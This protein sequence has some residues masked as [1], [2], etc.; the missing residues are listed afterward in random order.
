M[1]YAD[2]SV[3]VSYYC[4]EPLT[5]AVQ[6]AL[7]SAPRLVIS[8]LS[9]VEFASALSLKVRSHQLPAVA[10]HSV[11]ELFER[12]IREDYYRRAELEDEDFDAAQRWVATF[13]TPLRALDALH[14]AVAQRTQEELLTTD[15]LFAE[16]AETLSIRHR[17]I[18]G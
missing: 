3:L 17:L 6:T 18:H 14:L 13:T 7:R 11:W 10:A 5:H 1:A 8:R 16:A 4:S 2:T 15:K 9:E 12:H